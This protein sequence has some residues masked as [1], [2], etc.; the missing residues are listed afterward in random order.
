MQSYPCRFLQDK[1]LQN[2]E[3]TRHASALWLVVLG[4]TRVFHFVAL[5]AH[6]LAPGLNARELSMSDPASETSQSMAAQFRS[7]NRTFWLAGIMEVIERLGYYGL[8]TVVPVY[9]VLAI[10]EGGPE[11]THVQK[12]AIFAVWAAVQSFLPVF[13]GGFA[14]RYGYKRTVFVATVVKILG[15]LQMGFAVEFASMLTGGEST[16]VAGAP[17]TYN[18]FLSGAVLLAGG[19]AIF[20]PGL[21]PIIALQLNERNSSFGWSIFYQLVNVGGFLGPFLAGVIRLLAWKWVFVSCAVIVAFNFLML[22]TFPEPASGASESDHA[23]PWY[24]VLYRS[25]LGIFEPRVMSFLIVFSGFWLMFNQLF[26]LLP[27]FIDDWVDSRSI[28]SAFMNPS[29]APAE[30]AGRIPQ[31]FM[32]NINAGMCMLLAFAIGFL[33]GKIRAMRAMIAGMLIAAVAIWSLGLTMNGWWT[34]FAIAGFSLGELMASPTKLRYFGDIAPPGRKGLYLGY[35]NATNGIGWAVGSVIAGSLYE[36]NGDKVVLAR[37]YLR[38]NLG[39]DAAAVNDVPKS[40]VIPL[41]VEKTQSDVFGVMELLWTTYAPNQIWGTFALVG[42]ASAFGLIGFEIITRKAGHAEPALLLG[43]TW[44]IA[45]FVYLPHLSEFGTTLRVLM[46][47]GMVVV[48][49]V[50]T[51]FEYIRPDSLPWHAK[52]DGSYRA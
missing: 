2:L 14:D 46:A 24:V 3:K 18:I 22:L 35:I 19:T 36:E 21:Q 30:W 40:E 23:L 20:K 10:E 5:V 51:I 4:E 28:L 16:G 50:V 38:E 1:R 52:S 48:P 31:E 25:V 13:T 39:M 32:I 27:N 8:R 33:T 11:F 9:M 49:A 26:D 7:F 47:V 17:M 42:V 41:L 45:G 6:V 15:Y 37:R 34:L 12:G 43:L 29:E 44:L